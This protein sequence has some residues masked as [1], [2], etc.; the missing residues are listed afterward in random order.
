MFNKIREELSKRITEIC[1]P[2]L[3][4]LIGQTCYKMYFTKKQKGII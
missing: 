3:L 1:S 4:T 2:I